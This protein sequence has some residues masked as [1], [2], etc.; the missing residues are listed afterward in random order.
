MPR[1]GPN[2]CIVAE[3]A[4]GRQANIASS[5][6]RSKDHQAQQLLR[7]SSECEPPSRRVLPAELRSSLAGGARALHIC[8]LLC[9][10]RQRLLLSG[11]SAG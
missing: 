8:H 2:G 3:V 5:S 6:L 11:H 10:A 4:S 7:S 1:R 9:F